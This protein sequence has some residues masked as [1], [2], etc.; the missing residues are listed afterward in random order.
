MRRLAY[1]GI[2]AKPA[3][4]R[5]R[6]L[7]PKPAKTIPFDYVFEFK[8]EGR[9]GNRVQDVVEI[10]I[11][12][13]FVATSIGYSLVPN[14]QERPRFVTPVVDSASFPQNPVGVP[15][16]S[17][18]TNEE[19][20]PVF[21][22]IRVAGA[23]GTEI[24]VLHL[25]KVLPVFLGNNT[26]YTIGADGTVDVHFE[27]EDPS[28]IIRVWDKTNN[29]LSEL[30]WRAGGMTLTTPAIGPDPETNR[31]PA[32][33]DSQVF[34]Y[35]SPGRNVELFLMEGATTPIE[36]VES[37]DNASIIL[38][39][40]AIDTL[41]TGRTAVPITKKPL[42]PG[43]VL[44]VQ[45]KASDVLIPVSM[46]TVPRPRLSTLTLGA[47]TAGLETIGMDLTD[48]L[49]LDR[50]SANLALADPPLDRISPEDLNKIFESGCSSPE[51]VSFLYSIDVVSTGR[52]LQN[53]PIHNIAGLGIANGDRPFRP[54]AKPI[55]FQPRSSTR[56]QIEERSGPPGTL[57]IVLQGYKMLGTAQLPG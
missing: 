54:F 12:G 37:A 46:Y 1:P 20:P 7:S 23:P 40:E 39:K 34:V 35:G 44:M 25:T 53:R 6:D 13:H 11:E 9:R 14:E 32:A 33:G 17:E 24:A 26:K 3:A 51:D 43:D 2:A 38:A 8:L 41:V 36:K 31:L 4:E 18:G 49:R 28:G 50:N 21:K 42:A 19:T 16:F 56:I 48:G 27:N 29:R 30:L 57:Y 5:P 22:A 45:D 52:E 55:V 47:L 10:S 15:L